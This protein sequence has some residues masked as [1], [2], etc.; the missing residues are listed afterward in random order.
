[1]TLKEPESM[2]GCV[3]FT[4]RI[5]TND[6]YIK[7][8]VLKEL[9][10]KCNKS[11]MSKPKDPKTGRPKIRAVEYFCN[12]CSHSEEKKAH[13]DSLKVRHASGGSVRSQG[14]WWSRGHGDC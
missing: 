4:N 7:T 6:G 1:M 10:P 11:L 14:G 5:L 8:W 13:E 2:D 9:C 12:K 3:Y